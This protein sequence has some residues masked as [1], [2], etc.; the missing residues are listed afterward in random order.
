MAFD[1]FAGRVCP[2]TKVGMVFRC[3]D[4]DDARRYREF[5][6]IYIAA[7]E[8]PRILIKGRTW[9]VDSCERLNAFTGNKCFYSLSLILM[10]WCD[11]Q[12]PSN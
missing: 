6:E 1:F 7:V 11:V 4:S 2:T 5:L 3:N 9:V 12:F 8:E 10:D